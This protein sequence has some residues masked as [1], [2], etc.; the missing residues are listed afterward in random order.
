[1]GN[2]RTVLVSDLLTEVT[3]ELRDTGSTNYSST[4]LLAYLNRCYDDVYLILVDQE[5]ELVRTGTGTIT[6]V[7]GTQSYALSSNSMGDLLVPHRV[8][9]TNYE[10]M[11]LCEE[12]ELYDAINAEEAGDTSRT[13][14]DAYC[15]VGDYLWFKDVP[16]DAYTVNVRY[17]PNFVP[18]ASTD[19]MPLKNLFNN[20]FKEGIKVLAKHRNQIGVDVDAVLKD[21]FLSRAMKI[22]F[23][24][25]KR[26]VSF[27][28]R[29]R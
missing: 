7:D 15:V 3:Y 23:T 9:V 26:K 11:L 21:I 13:L 14:P 12:E 24:R 6:T 8:W 22:V 29:F 28:P 5:S 17:F 19:N 16:D 25:R 1:M 2:A 20:E 10:P 4:E 27:S 18:V